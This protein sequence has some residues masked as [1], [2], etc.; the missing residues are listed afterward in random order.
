MKYH[1]FA[2]HDYY[3]SGGMGDWVGAY[4]SERD[5]LTALATRNYDWWHIVTFDPET[6]GP[7][8]ISEG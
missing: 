6:G 8:D 2:G 7:T 4:D 3:P 5:A 1:L